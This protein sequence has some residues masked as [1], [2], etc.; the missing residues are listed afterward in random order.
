MFFRDHQKNL[1]TQDLKNI[2]DRFLQVN[3]IHFRWTDFLLG[4]LKVNACRIFH[5]KLETVVKLPGLIFPTAVTV[6]RDCCIYLAFKQYPV[7]S[8][9]F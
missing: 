7:S 3:H 8:V 5:V 2:D 1:L 9:A 6:K 4:R